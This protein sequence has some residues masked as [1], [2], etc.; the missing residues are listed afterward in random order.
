MTCQL[1]EVKFSERNPKALY[2]EIVYAFSNINK[3]LKNIKILIINFSFVLIPHRFQKYSLLKRQY[4]ILILENKILPVILGELKIHN[5]M[6]YTGRRC[7]TNL[8]Y[9]KMVYVVTNA[10]LNCKNKY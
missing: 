2:T 7:R 1:N 10:I 9:H 4:G 8:K 6:M 3:H 5:V